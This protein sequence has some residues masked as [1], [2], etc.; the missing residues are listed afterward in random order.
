MSGLDL[1]MRAERAVVDGAPAPYSIA[2]AGGRVVAVE[3]G[4]DALA[5]AGAARHAQ[6]GSDVVLLPGLVDTHVHL[7]DPG[8][9]EWEDFESATRAAAAG[10][11]TTLVDMP[12][13]SVPVTVSLDALE[14]KRSRAR[15][16]VRVDV[17]FWAG[18]TPTNLAEL[19]GLHDAGVMGFK[20]FLANTG[21][22]EFP[23]VDV[24]QMRSAMAELARLDALLIVHAEDAGQIDR[25][26]EASTRRYLDFLAS[27]PK[28]IENVAV[29]AVIDAARE[30]GGRAHVL[31]LSSG[32]GVSLLAAARR[33]GVPV[34]AETCPHYLALTAEEVPDGAT[35]FKTAPPIREAANNQRLWDGLADGTIGLVVSDHS[36]CTPDM[37]QV[38]T[39]DFGGAFGGS[40][41][42]QITL[43]IVWTAARDRGFGIDDVAR[44]MS[45]APAALT[46]MR[47]KGRIAVGYDADFCVLAPEETFV[48][49]PG[50][51]HHKQPLTAF[52]GRTL[53]GV[54]RQTWLRGEPVGDTPRGELLDRRT[55]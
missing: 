29:T 9:T 6:L 50:R 24:A 5:D 15:G 21:L 35:E 26:P 52:A 44:W 55:A 13:D 12:L 36:P 27:R 30:T 4:L 40:A 33:A 7:Q 46:R 22:P 10:G 18:V 16:R 39:G 31:H 17:G 8:H 20:C 49:D 23:P 1:V 11:I 37:K 48:V 28:Q 42:L 47:H 54:V 32:D 14:V 25:H 43:P 2:V 34:T 53:A 45:T 51:L 38:D 3:P 41:S 19:A